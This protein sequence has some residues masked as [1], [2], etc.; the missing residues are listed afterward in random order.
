[1]ADDQFDLEAY[2][3]TT[4]DV[5]KRY[6]NPETRTY[7]SDSRD[8]DIFVHR[9]QAGRVDTFIEC[10][11]RLHRAAPCTHFF[12]V[13]LPL[14]IKVYLTY[15]RGMLEHWGETQSKVKKIILGFKHS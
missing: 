8:Q 9:D 6:Y 11:N 14:K 7:P 1:L 10:S 15:R 3:P 5:S 13:G 2:T 12:Y 4:M